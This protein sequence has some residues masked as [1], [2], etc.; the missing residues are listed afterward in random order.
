MKLSAIR[1]APPSG[2]ADALVVF[3]HG[4]GASGADLMGLADLLRPVLPQA[5]FVAPDAPFVC[6]QNP[7]G[8]EWFDLQDADPGRR[9]ATVEASLEAVG[10]LL[11]TLL[12]ET[13]ISASHTALVG[14]SQ[15]TMMALVAGLR[16]AHPPMGVVGFSG[17]LPDAARLKTTLRSRPPV[18]LVHGTVDEVVP[19]ELGT[20]ARDTLIGLGV[21]VEFHASQGAAHTI[22]PDGLAFAA[23]FLGRCAA[24]AKG[25]KP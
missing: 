6:G 4:Y 23:R 16:R 9:A 10:G 5:L 11:D 13:R 8:F 15:G 3:L 22:A 20:W 7:A 2:A 19:F 24:D 14:F 12:H 25:G 1:Q 17:F 18:C 21:A